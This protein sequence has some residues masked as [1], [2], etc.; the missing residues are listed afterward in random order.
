MY[1]LGAGHVTLYELFPLFEAPWSSIVNAL[2]ASAIVTPSFMSRATPFY[3]H[4]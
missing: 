2:G 3:T 4:G 1:S